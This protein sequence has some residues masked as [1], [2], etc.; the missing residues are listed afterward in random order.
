MATFSG[1]PSAVILRQKDDGNDR[2]FSMDRDM[3]KV[4]TAIDG[5]RSLADIT[6]H[7]GM[8][9]NLIREV[10]QRLLDADVAEV[11]EKNPPTLHR[12]SLA[13]YSFTVA[14]EPAPR[15]A[16]VESPATETRSNSSSSFMDFLEEH[17]ALAIGPIASVMIEDEIELMDE[18]WK[19]FPIDRA[20]EL[21]NLL[22]RQ[23]PREAK[24]MTFQQAMIQLLKDL[25]R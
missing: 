8:P 19:K 22:A 11:A 7:T 2:E 21:I 15:S 14:S 4:F 23:I 13:G 18:T 16:P 25:P 20:P 3:L 5:K 12:Q 17:L 24:R 1:N 10:I 6:A 9:P